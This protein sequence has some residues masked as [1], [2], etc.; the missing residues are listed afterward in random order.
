LIQWVFLLKK[1]IMNDQPML[2][3]KVETLVAQARQE[4]KQH[5]KKKGAT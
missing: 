2:P 1:I 3:D 5:L 4:L